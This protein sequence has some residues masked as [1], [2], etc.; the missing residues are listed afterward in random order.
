MWKSAV[1]CYRFQLMTLQ[2]FFF[3]FFLMQESFS[4]VQTR[5]PYKKM[6]LIIPIWKEML[7]PCSKLQA[8]S[9]GEFLLR[10]CLSLKRFAGSALL[11][12]C[13]GRESIHQKEFF[14]YYSL[15]S[16]SKQNSAALVE[17]AFLF[18]GFFMLW[19]AVIPHFSLTLSLMKRCLWNVQV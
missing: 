12:N 15:K 2:N 8:C 7:F 13:L 1:W 17:K 16:V 9:C 19:R 18:L 3:F 5:R 11:A 4:V 14:F 6:Y 10:A